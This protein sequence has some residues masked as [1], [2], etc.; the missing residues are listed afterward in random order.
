MYNKKQSSK[1]LFA[2]VQLADGEIRRKHPTYKI[3]VE[4]IIFHRTEEEIVNIRKKE[5]IPILHTLNHKATELL[6]KY[7]EKKPFYSAKLH[8]A[9]SYMLNNWE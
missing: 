5:A 3:E 2:E 8:Q 6:S 1:P 7:D 9:L 4:H